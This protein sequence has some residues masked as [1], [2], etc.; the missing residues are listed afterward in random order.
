MRWLVVTKYCGKG[1][2]NSLNIFWKILCWSFEALW[3]GKWLMRNWDGAEF[4][5]ATDR[6]RAG[7]YLADGYYGV[8]W[9]I[10]ADLDHLA[11]VLKLPAHNNRTSRLYT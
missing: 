7:T 8:L 10:R 3:T 6:A 5:S 11:K 2:T 4:T 1:A 9:V